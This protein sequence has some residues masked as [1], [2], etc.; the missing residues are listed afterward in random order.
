MPKGMRE[1]RGSVG[2]IVISFLH[3]VIDGRMYFG[4]VEVTD[5]DKL[6]FSPFAWF[7]H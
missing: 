6:L 4:G 3:G 5:P 2:F 1:Q 7:V